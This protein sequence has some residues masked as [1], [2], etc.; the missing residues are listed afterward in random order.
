MSLLEDVFS[1]KT[2]SYCEDGITFK[3]AIIKTPLYGEVEIDFSGVVGNE[4]ANH[5][6][7]L[8]DFSV[9]NYIY[10]QKQRSKGNTHQ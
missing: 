5:K 2:K 6:N 7:A 4:I 10:Y 9:E 3:T 1:G 8:Y